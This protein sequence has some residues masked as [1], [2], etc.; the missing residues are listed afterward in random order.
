[1]KHS[2]EDLD[3]IVNS[4]LSNRRYLHSLGVAKL[5]KELAISHGIDPNKAYIAGLLHDITKEMNDEYQD[6]L[7]K[8]H[9]D[10]DKINVKPKVK[11]SYSSKYYLLD[12]L[13][14]DDEDILDAVYNHTIC[15][16][17]N[18]LALIVYIADKREE[19]R[20]INDDIVA[21]SHKNLKLGY[22]ML[23]KDVERYLKS[24]G[25]K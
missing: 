6:A 17:N 5:A 24:K 2:I 7:F 25:I 14:I 23:Q 8:K 4:K 13:G 18:P 9:N 21:T 20:G 11:H 1:M 16:S 15:N 3:K 19:N 10:L 12:E 22:E